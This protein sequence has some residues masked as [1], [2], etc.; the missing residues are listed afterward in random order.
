MGGAVTQRW[1]V[2][3]RLRGREFFAQP[4]D[5]GMQL[6]DDRLGLLN[7]RLEVFDASSV[8]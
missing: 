2:Q 7:V 3:L 6:K 5:L 4:G 8:M 1:G